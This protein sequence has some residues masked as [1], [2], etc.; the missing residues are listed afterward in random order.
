MEALYDICHAYLVITSQK[1]MKYVLVLEADGTVS[2]RIAYDKNDGAI[3]Y[4]KHKDSR[5]VWEGQNGW[6]YADSIPFE[7]IRLFYEQKF[8]ELSRHYNDTTQIEGKERQD[9][10][11]SFENL[12][13]FGM[14]RYDEE[15]VFCLCSKRIREE[16]Y[17]E[18]DFLSYLCYELFERGQY[19][20]VTLTY[21]ADFYCGAT[22]R[23]KDL[24]YAAK[25][26]EVNT[27]KLAE[28]I[29]TQMLFSESMYHEEKIFLDYYEGVPYFRIKQAYLAYIS[30]EY[31]VRDRAVDCCV[32]QIIEKECEQGETLADICEIA[33]LKWYSGEDLTGHEELLRGWLRKLCMKGIVFPFYLTYPEEWLREV[34]LFDKILIQYKAK[35]PGSKVKL[36]YQIVRDE[37]EGGGFETE[38]LIP[39]YEEIYVKAFTLYKDERLRYYFKETAADGSTVTEKRSYVKR[40]WAH[41][42]KYGRLN[43]MS[44][45]PDEKLKEAMQAY[46][47]ED[48][49]ADSLFHVY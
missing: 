49:V 18:D 32:F 40:K 13:T 46:A 39:T 21:L 45:L 20:K 8:V 15:N 10:E 27:K 30:R 44:L 26:Y 48:A 3:V 47:L 6:H 11:L 43:E 2:Q 42:G 24:W 14:E 23:M 9:R 28:R 4:L 22:E 36:H 29:I 7:S 25:R 37:S 41:A 5:I 35:K 12:Q 31:V 19:D 1:G 33:L 17:Q 16:N 34:Q 38:I